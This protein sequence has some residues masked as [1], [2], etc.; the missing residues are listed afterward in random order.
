MESNGWELKNKE[1]G[2]YPITLTYWKNGSAEIVLY[3]GIEQYY[4]LAAF[5]GMGQSF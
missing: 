3:L 1:T 4:E 5:L 2:D